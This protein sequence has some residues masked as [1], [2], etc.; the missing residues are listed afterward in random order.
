M[1]ATRTLELPQDFIARVQRY[2]EDAS[3]GRLALSEDA[4][5][6][7]WRYHSSRAAITFNTTSVS[8]SGE[9]G[10]YIPPPASSFR[11]RVFDFLRRQYKR[12]VVFCDRLMR[13]PMST[14]MV[15]EMSYD[16]VM[17]RHPYVDYD[18]NPYRFDPRRLRPLFK[19]SRDLRKKWFLRDRFQARSSIVTAAYFHAL[20]SHFLEGNVRLY[21]EIGA[22]NGNLASLFH[23]YNKAHVVIIDLPETILYSSCYLAHV[24]PDA[25]VVLP[26]EIEGPLD[27]KALSATGFVFMLP[28]QIDL[29]PSNSFDLI[30]N[31]FSMQ[32]MT[33]DQV[34]KYLELVQRIGAHRSLWC[35][36]NRAE[37]VPS[38]TER[39]MRA[40]EFEYAKSNEVLVYEVD[41]YMRLT[42]LDASVTHIERI[43]KTR[44]ANAVTP[45]QAFS[46]P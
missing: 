28:S 5:S 31:L 33:H 29:L 10:F 3:A 25:T 42:Q 9:S 6:D 4:K 1:S 24:F 20:F 46:V 36:V 39:P 41:R 34:N 15:P 23:H 13:C 22:G 44:S 11:Y 43:I 40:F 18:E 27:V 19:T 32:E 14:T 38:K 17:T 37:K 21:A 16:Y 26:N 12:T 35:N 30:T 45:P 8:I 2:Q 7:Y